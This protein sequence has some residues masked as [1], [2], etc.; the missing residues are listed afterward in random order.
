MTMYKAGHVSFLSTIEVVISI[1]YMS[2]LV[3][4]KPAVLNYHHINY[5]SQV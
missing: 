3:L 1:V 5:Y 2:P 4:F